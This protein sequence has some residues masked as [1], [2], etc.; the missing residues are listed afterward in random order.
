MKQFY[1]YIL[2]NKNKRVLYAGVTSNLKK[3]MYQ[4]KTKYYPKSFTA[5]Y[6][7]DMLMYYE[8]YDT[9]HEAI[10][11]E[12]QLKAGSRIKKENLVELENP[13]WNDLS[14]EWIFNF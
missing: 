14:E 12:K 11:R 7:C 4:H 13:E 2:T 10:G 3:R 5:K 6:N 1:V 8:V 9:S